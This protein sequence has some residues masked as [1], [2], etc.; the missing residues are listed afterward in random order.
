MGMGQESS[1]QGDLKGGANRVRTGEPKTNLIQTHVDLIWAF[2]ELTS[3]CDS[4]EP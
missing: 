3:G 1:A 2:I 4:N